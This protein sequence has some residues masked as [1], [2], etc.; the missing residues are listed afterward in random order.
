MMVSE[1]APLLTLGQLVS[2]PPGA[3][4]SELVLNL[5]PGQSLRLSIMLDD[6]LVGAGQSL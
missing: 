1:L 5:G 2:V 6:G 4:G 3:Q